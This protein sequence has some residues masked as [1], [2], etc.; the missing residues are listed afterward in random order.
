GAL[1][2]VVLLQAIES[3]LVVIG[4]SA[5]WQQIAVGSIMIGAVGLDALRQ[6]LS[7]S[8]AFSRAPS[9]RKPAGRSAEGIVAATVAACLIGSFVYLTQIRNTARTPPSTERTLAWLTPLRD[10]PVCR[11]WQA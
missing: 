10:R 3:G 7:L 8:G 11:I 2:G 5:N 4:V 1:L 6:R 9:P